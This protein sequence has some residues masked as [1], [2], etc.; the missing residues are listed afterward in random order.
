MSREARWAA[1]KAQY[2]S[3]DGMGAGGSAGGH[4]GGGA[5]SPPPPGVDRDFDAMVEAELAQR[6]NRG[7]GGY[8]GH[9]GHGG[10]IPLNGPPAQGSDPA[11]ADCGCAMMPL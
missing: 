7:Q 4:A 2:E 3:G 11:G 10:Q 1:K 5:N 6:A 9:G 8:G